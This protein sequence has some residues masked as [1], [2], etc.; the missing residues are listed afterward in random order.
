MRSS[1]L[2]RRRELTPRG[3]DIETGKNR[4]ASSM[5]DERPSLDKTRIYGAQP[6]IVG[7]RGVR[8]YRHRAVDTLVSGPEIASSELG[9]HF[10]TTAD[11]RRSGRSLGYALGVDVGPQSSP[12]RR[13]NTPTSI[14]RSAPPGASAGTRA[15][16][17]GCGVRRR[18]RLFRR[19]R[20]S[21]RPRPR[22]VARGGAGTAR[23]SAQNRAC[24]G[25]RKSATPS[26]RA[27]AQSDHE[28]IAPRIAIMLC[29]ASHDVTSARR[30]IETIRICPSVPGTVGRVPR[31]LTSSCRAG[32]AVGAVELQSFF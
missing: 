10:G 2:A 11:A 17:L 26:P 25:S 8:E 1:A 6:V 30:R 24:G 12:K 7:A 28:R 22:A 14:S 20:Y 23:R 16:P 3:T 31:G 18:R 27:S 5:H 19:G 13:K 32:R 4:I 15:R 21:G 9:C 29:C